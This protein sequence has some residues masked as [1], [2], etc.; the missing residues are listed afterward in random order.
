MQ[1]P[2]RTNSMATASLVMGLVGF[3][4]GFTAI[5]AIIFGF[6]A[7]NQIKQRGEGGDGMATAGIVLG[8]II[9]AMMV[10]YL[11]FIIAFIGAAGI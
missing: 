9:V 4:T 2:P 5:L 7:K 3:C 10:I 1:G 11:F 6:I 8:F